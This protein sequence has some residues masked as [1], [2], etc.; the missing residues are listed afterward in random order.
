MTHFELGSLGEEIIKDIVEIAG[1]GEQRSYSS[2]VGSLPQLF[3]K[4]LKFVEDTLATRG[5]NDG[6]A[7]LAEQTYEAMQK[8]EKRIASLQRVHGSSTT[9]TTAST[10][11][12]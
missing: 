3:E 8:I 5:A 7:Y 9:S 6:D 2:I 1:E 10:A 12:K 4:V 11:S